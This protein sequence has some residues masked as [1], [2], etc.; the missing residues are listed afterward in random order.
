M[1]FVDWT[2][3]Q[4]G[5]SMALM[6]QPQSAEHLGASEGTWAIC[7]IRSEE[8]SVEQQSG[9]GALASNW[10]TVLDPVLDNATCHGCEPRL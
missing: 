9:R 3:E 2:E 7:T 6:L 4:P 5:R 10:R 8:A 1:N